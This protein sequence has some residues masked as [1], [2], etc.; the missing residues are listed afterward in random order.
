MTRLNHRSATASAFIISALLGVFAPGAAAQEPFYKG[1]RLSL[2]INFGAGSSTDTEARLFGRH[3]AK[4]I[5]GQPEL[6]MQNMEGAGGLNGAMHLS[7]VGPNDGTRMGYLTALAW[8]Y[9][10]EPDRFRVDLK[11][12]RFVGYQ[13]GT[14]VY[15]VRSDVPPGIKQATDIVKAKDLVSGGISARSGR[16]VTI[17]M[18]LDMLGVPFK[19]V[20]GYRSGQRA[21]LALERN[22]I[23]F[24]SST[25]PGY[26]AQIEPNFVKPGKVTALYFDP[27]WDGKT[28]SVSPQVDGLPI[29]PF[30]EL[31]RKINGKLPSGPL[32]EAYLA[33]I[34]L[35]GK[36]Q[37]LVALPPGTPQ[38]ALDALRAALR[39]LNDD[40]E[41]AAEATKVL[42]FVPEYY[43]GADTDDHVRNALTMSPDVRTFM[44]GYLKQGK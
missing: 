43:A 44:A 42:K 35:N 41:F 37:R 23:Q 34:T 6:I 32:W 8:L 2:L 3:F 29:L 15:F 38:P 16:D 7:E 4:H 10:N 19:H 11:N 25:T 21:M 31:Y 39:R 33:C 14:A 9:G 1:K 28:F 30:Q 22:E 17:R 40:K 18:T 12:F 24:Y 20:T 27:N 36:L 5:D 26:R 13:S